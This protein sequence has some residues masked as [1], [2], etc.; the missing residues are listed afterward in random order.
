MQSPLLKQ[1][2]VNFTWDEKINAAFGEC[3]A[4]C[5]SSCLRQKQN[6]HDENRT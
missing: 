5:F 3:G 1:E 2:H 4:L 6:A